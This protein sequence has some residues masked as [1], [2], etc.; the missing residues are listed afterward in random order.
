[1]KKLLA[2]FF[3]VLTLTLAG[4]AT[5]DH[6]PSPQVS[7]NA[8]WAVIPFVNNTETPRAGEQAASI[9]AGLLR[10]RGIKYVTYYNPHIKSKSLLPDQHKQA[11]IKYALKQAKRR[12]SMYALTGTVNEWR[13]KAGLDGEPV[14]G[15]TLDLI[16]LKTNKIIW[17]AVASDTGNSHNSVSD[18]AQSLMMKSLKSLRVA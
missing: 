6:T 10:A 3:S 16:N 7:N 2:L 4:C 18:V 15:V 14:V 8:K 13:Y 11:K 1:M 9:S 17:S 5:V 12:G